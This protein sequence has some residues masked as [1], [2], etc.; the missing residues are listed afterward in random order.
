VY[1]DNGEPAVGAVLATGGIAML[2]WGM[3]VR[4]AE[5]P[6][7]RRTS[8]EVRRVRVRIFYAVGDTTRFWLSAGYLEWSRVEWMRLWL[9]AM[10][11]RGRRIPRM[12][13]VDRQGQR[14]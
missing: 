5:P 6:V 11:N 7:Y 1:D 13:V 10:M 14:R 2:G 8:R 9:R 3:H 4:E 12:H